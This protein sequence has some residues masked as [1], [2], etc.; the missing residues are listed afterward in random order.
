MCS[1]VLLLTQVVSFW[2]R[3]V[4][5][6]LSWKG[7]F[8]RIIACLNPENRVLQEVFLSKTTSVL[9]GKQCD[10]RSC[11]DTTCFTLTN[12]CISSCQ[13][14]RLIWRKHSLSQPWKQSCR[15]HY[16]L[17]LTLFSQVNTLLNV[18][19][20][21]TNGFPSRETCV[22]STKLNRPISKKES[23]LHMENLRCRKYFFQKLIQILQENNVL[24]APG[25]NT[26]S[27]LF[28]DN[29]CFSNLVW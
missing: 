26:D 27:F 29:V 17:K 8:A 11:F 19:P 13:L 21:S 18:P 23:L 10:S 12:T 1:I 24:D 5:L 7:R 22:Y 4:F 9:T 2:D 20:S 3:H 6:P 14:T 28:R 25:P 15:K 16:V